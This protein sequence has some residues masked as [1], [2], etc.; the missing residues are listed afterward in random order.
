MI[1]ITHF[2]NSYQPLNPFH[3][4]KS[5]MKQ[6]KMW[7]LSIILVNLILSSDVM[8]QAQQNPT[9]SFI[10]KEKVVEIGDTLTLS[11]T[12]QF[13]NDYPVHWIKINSENQDNNLFISRGSTVNIINSRY[14]VTVD[15]SYSPYSSSSTY[16]LR[17]DK[18][19][20]VD[21]GRYSCQIITGSA[22]KETAET[23]VFVRIPPIISDNSTRSVITTIGSNVDLYCNAD[24]YP[25]P[26]IHW[27]R[28]KNKL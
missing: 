25:R 8:V 23:D 26:M 18:V 7:I 20:E 2:G 11:C 17:I 4:P 1:N 19:Q 12:V 16:T 27:R 13:S 5:S 24:G 10:T 14:S 9:I 22:S 15:H 6:F 3:G 28:E 21:S